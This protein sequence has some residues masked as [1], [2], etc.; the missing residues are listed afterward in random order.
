[1]NSFICI[2]KKKMS[3]E[4]KCH[5]NSN[6]VRFSLSKNLRQRLR[7]HHHIDV[8]THHHVFL[9]EQSIE[10]VIPVRIISQREPQ[11]DPLHLF[12]TDRVMNRFRSDY[13]F[14]I[15]DGSDEWS[16]LNG[17]FR[18]TRK[19]LFYPQSGHRLIA[20]I[21]WKMLMRH[22]CL[23]D[24]EKDIFPDWDVWTTWSQKKWTPVEKH[25]YEVN[26]CISK[27]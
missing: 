17:C 12:V 19:R 24:I 11:V 15:L 27:K 6:M 16:E 18:H 1:M 25:M 9:S 21:V 5:L 13:G 10:H 26:Q 22:S 20:H 4:N 3:Q 14:G 7:L 2:D 23:R 8:Y